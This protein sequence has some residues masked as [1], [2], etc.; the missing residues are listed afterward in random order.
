[1]R[2]LLLSV[3][4]GA[5][6]IGASACSSGTQHAA[7]TSAKTSAPVPAVSRGTD[8][9]SL[10]NDLNGVTRDLN[11]VDGQLSQTDGDLSKSSEGDVQQ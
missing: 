1:M 6:V 3:A 7:T 8:T 5:L 10:Q 2:K 9:A 11:G 4:A